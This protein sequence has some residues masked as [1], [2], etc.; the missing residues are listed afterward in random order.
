VLVIVS[1][2]FSVVG[3]PEPVAFLDPARQTWGH[4]GVL[5]FFAI[6]GY[7]IAGSWI[8][9]PSVPRF[10]A[11]RALRIMPGLFVATAMSAWLVG[12][13]VTALSPAEYFTT[14][15]VLLYPPT[16]TLVYFSPS[17][18][19]P[20]VFPHNP[21][22]DINAS[23][24]T[25]PIEVTCYALL[26]LLMLVRLGRVWIMLPAAVLVSLAGNVDLREAVG[27]SLPLSPLMNDVAM[28]AAA[29]FVGSSLYLLRD[30]IPLRI[31]AAA[32]VL[33]VAL[34]AGFTPLGNTAAVL[35]MPY[36]VLTLGLRVP[37][38]PLGAYRG[39]DLSYGTYVLAFPIQQAV[40]HFS[41]TGSP[42]VITGISLPIVLGLAALSWRFVERP[43]LQLAHRLPGTRSRT[44][45]SVAPPEGRAGGH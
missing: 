33:V 32:I 24:W 12:P 13:L 15:S 30:R 4:F 43:A 29:F 37:A 22:Q 8:S 28:L 35:L 23:L 44:L 20:E 25:L 45:G 7:L 21:M 42:W 6:S 1:H 14:P 41:G 36:V 34:A 2:S 18:V 11:K 39:W 19:L 31:P 17:L 10:A 26:M 16:E 40:E 27:V 3:L 5:V 9:D 38:V